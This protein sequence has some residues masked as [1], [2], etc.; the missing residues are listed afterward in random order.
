MNKVIVEKTKGIK[1]SSN[2]F[3]T[4][5]CTVLTF[6]NLK[7]NVI[8]Y[9][10]GRKLYKGTFYLIETKGLR[11]TRNPFWSDKEITSCQSQTLGIERH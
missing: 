1:P 6:L 10:W 7:F 4:L 9:A 3:Y 5:L 2:I 8:Q 11:L